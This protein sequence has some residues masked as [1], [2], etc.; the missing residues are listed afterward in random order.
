M[1]EEGRAFSISPDGRTIVYLGTEQGQ[2]HLYRRELGS[3]RSEPIEGTSRAWGFHFFSPDGSRLAFM[4]EEGFMQIPV[5]GGRATLVSSEHAYG[6]GDWGEKGG[7]LAGMS[8]DSLVRR[9][10]FEGAAPGPVTE[11]AEGET[12]H[13]FPHWLSDGQRFVFTV[14]ADGGPQRI[15]I[16]KLGESGHQILG[17][18]GR[19]HV[20]DSGHLLYE[21]GDRDLW[22]VAFDEASGEIV[23]EPSLLPDLPFRSRTLLSFDATAGGDLVYMPRSGTAHNELVWIDRQGRE[24]SLGLPPGFFLHPSVSADAS[25]IAFSSLDAA[26]AAGLLRRRDRDGG[27]VQSQRCRT[28]VPV[29]GRNDQGPG[30]DLGVGHPQYR[31]TGATGSRAGSLDPR[32]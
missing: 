1:R 24:T 6:G 9:V 23:G 29:V 8:A 25:R 21:K 14:A 31:G 19:P 32:R 28:R 5:A 18:G 15:A 30:V 4:S 22:L 7:I 10:P 26:A 16:A 11:L 13:W 2:R 27:R 3:L 17:E 12:R 20:L